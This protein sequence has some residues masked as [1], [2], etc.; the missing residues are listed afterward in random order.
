MG[1]NLCPD[2]IGQKA[3]AEILALVRAGKV[4]AVVGEVVGF[5][6]LPPAMTRMRDRKTTGRV[7]VRLD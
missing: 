2:T 3:M 4:R 1:W 5:D 6:Q 7:I